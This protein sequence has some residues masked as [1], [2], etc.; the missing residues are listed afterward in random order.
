MS[1]GVPRRATLSSSSPPVR[2]SPVAP[3]ALKST[4]TRV[5]FIAFT[6]MLVRISPEA[7]TSAPE[8]IKAFDSMTKPA[9]AAAT[10][11]AE[12]RKEITTGMSAPPMGSVLVMPSNTAIAAIAQLAAVPSN[13]TIA[14]AAATAAAARS[15]S[16]R[17]WPGRVMDLPSMIPWSFPKATKL[18]ESVRAPMKIEMATVTSVRVAS[19]AVSAL[20]ISAS[21]TSAEEPP[22][23]PLKAATNCGMAV[24]S[25]DRARYAP[26]PPPTTMPAMIAP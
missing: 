16:I 17:R 5:R 25:T 19:P 22:P 15:G 18:P 23:N 10:P 8:M 1:S 24:I 14:T 4:A 9:A 21:A 7:P 6:M 3:K 20:D 12:F 2:A 11:D 13:T 26:T